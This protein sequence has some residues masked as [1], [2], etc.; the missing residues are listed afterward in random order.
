MNGKRE[1]FKFQDNALKAFVVKYTISNLKEAE[2]FMKR[3]L[4][5]PKC[6]VLIGCYRFKVLRS[7]GG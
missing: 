6:S 2:I 4:K 3:T 7:I 1:F 5:E